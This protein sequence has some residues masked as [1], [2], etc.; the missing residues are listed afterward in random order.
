MIKDDYLDNLEEKMYRSTYCDGIIDIFSGMMFVIAGISTVLENFGIHR[1]ITI[2]LFVPPVIVMFANGKYITTSRLGIVRLG[3]TRQKNLRRMRY[4]FWIIATTTPVLIILKVSGAYH[5]IWTGYF[6]SC[7]LGAY[8]FLTLG[9]TAYIIDFRR[10]YILAVLG[11]A[12]IPLN[13]YLDGQFGIVLPTG[14]LFY[15][16][17]LVVAAYGGILLRRFIKENPP[18]EEVEDSI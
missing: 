11:G 4:V 18:I 7:V 15:L 14:I 13:K 2:I 9:L 6:K 16:P 10:L 17:G 3:V 8:I 5:H 1:V 12:A